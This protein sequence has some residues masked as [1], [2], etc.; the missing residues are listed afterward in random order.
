MKPFR[1]KWATEISFLHT[2][3]LPATPHLLAITMDKIWEPKFALRF[4]G[5]KTVLS[6]L[7]DMDLLFPFIVQKHCSFQTLHAQKL[8]KASLSPAKINQNQ[9]F[10]SKSPKIGQN[11]VFWPRSTKIRF[12]AK[13]DQN[14]LFQP[15]MT[16]T[17]CF[18]QNWSKPA[19][20]ANINQ[21]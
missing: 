6:C 9:C 20:P 17:S 16:K 14:Q 3:V 12:S 15:K 18:G 11:Q 10:Q 7:L 19:F 8:I 21:C 1:T 5:L 4:L 2:P 13:M